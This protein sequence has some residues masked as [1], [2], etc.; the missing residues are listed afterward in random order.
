MCG[1]CKTIKGSVVVEV[2]VL[3]VLIITLGVMVWQVYLMRDEIKL[4]Q[5]P[6]FG[7]I[8]PKIQFFDKDTDVTKHEIKF[9][10][11]FENKGPVPANG[12]KIDIALFIFKEEPKSW[13]KR[14]YKS[15][16][17]RNLAKDISILPDQM[18]PISCTRNLKEVEDN[19]PRDDKGLTTPRY[20]YI[21]TTIEYHGV[22]KEPKYFQETLYV[23]NW[24]P[25][26]NKIIGNYL[27]FS[28]S[29]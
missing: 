18:Y 11:N 17:E 19:V 1:L 12:I 14:K 21:H 27:R 13:R 2:I 9:T 26:C 24:S 20:L 10:M 6:F 3:A 25:A 8:R 4:R 29:N 5:R 23:F 22:K 28:K 15:F 16:E 7:L